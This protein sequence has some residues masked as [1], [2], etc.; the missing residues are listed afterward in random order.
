MSQDAPTF[1]LQSH[2]R[3]SDGA[4]AAGE[5]VAAAA[6][7]GVELLALTDHDTVDGV[8]EAADA[9]AQ[10]GI[11][12]VTGVE[13]SALD[14]TGLD[15]HILG[16][17]IDDGDPE[18]LARLELYRADRERRNQAMIAALRELGFELDEAPLERRLAKGKPIGRPHIAAAV[19][20]HPANAERLLSEGLAEPSAF[21][22]AY[23]ADD[24][25]ALRPRRLPSVREAI[26]AIHD[27]G[28]VAIWAHP[29]WDVS[30]PADVLA[31]IDRFRA[32][33][34]DGVECFY[35]THTAEQ[36]TLAAERCA[37]L[38]LLSTGSSDFHGPEH[39]M[40]SRFRAFS[41]YGLTPQLGPI[42][43]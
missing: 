3:H 6:E 30:A 23:L 34:I 11:R 37:E 43:A 14:E 8:R 36:T 42:A 26:D 10:V 15:L 41:T 27:A 24:G 4:L 32:E 20:E 13:I 12:L 33:G 19:T 22:G 16:Y 9:A 28:G 39:R 25:P 18:L 31:A 35:L 2:S 21:L 1:D 7:A 38:G 40:M 5:V 17:L 29:F